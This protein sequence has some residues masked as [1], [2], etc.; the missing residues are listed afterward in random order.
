MAFLLSLGVWQRHEVVL[1]EKR[2][3]RGWECRTG[4]EGRCYSM[5]AKKGE[6]GP[7]SGI[8]GRSRRRTS[9][10]EERP[11]WRGYDQVA[12]RSIARALGARGSYADWRGNCWK[13]DRERQG[14][15]MPFVRMQAFARLKRNR[16]IMG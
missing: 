15:V 2:E 11:R 6:D 5:A 1:T 12:D 8:W 7:L 13:E 9:E 10:R 4:H 14:G 3:S 16:P